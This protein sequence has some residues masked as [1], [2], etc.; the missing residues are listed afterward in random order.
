MAQSGASVHERKRKERERERERVKGKRARRVRREKFII[1]SM[2][3][4]DRKLSKP[5]FFCFQRNGQLYTLLVYDSVTKFSVKQSV[6]CTSSNHLAVPRIG[7]G[8]SILIILI[9]PDYRMNPGEYR[10]RP[11]S[12]RIPTDHWRDHTASRFSVVRVCTE[13][14]AEERLM[15]EWVSCLIIFT[16]TARNNLYQLLIL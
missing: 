16:C 6:T 15:R 1:F 14:S 3:K 12:T 2:K 4:I 10:F 9:S 5:F 11:W 13:G 7:R 8:K